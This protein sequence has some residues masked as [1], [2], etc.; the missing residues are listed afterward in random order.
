[1]AIGRFAMASGSGHGWPTA[2]VVVAVAGRMGDGTPGISSYPN[3]H[4]GGFE[5]ADSLHQQ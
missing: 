4:D 2:W 5:H 3:I 1:L